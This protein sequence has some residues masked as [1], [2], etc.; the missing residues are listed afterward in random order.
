[1]SSW[2]DTNARHVQLTF[3]KITL[4]PKVGRLGSE[5]AVKTAFMGLLVLGSRFV[6]S[7]WRVEVTRQMGLALIV[8]MRGQ[9]FIFLGSEER[10]NWNVDTDKVGS[11]QNRNN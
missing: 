1:M 2:N 5:I 3:Y 7:A 8:R 11:K 4:P 9:R 10:L 6:I